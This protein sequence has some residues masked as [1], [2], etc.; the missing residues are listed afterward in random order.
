MKYFF[1]VVLL[2]GTFTLTSAKDENKS[3]YGYPDGDMQEYKE[4]SAYINNPQNRDS[5]VTITAIGQ[6]VAPSFATSPAQAYALAKRAAT[7]DAYRVIAERV[8]GVRI[9]GKD[10]IKNM[11]IKSSYV[12]TKV[13]AMIRN[14]KIIET[15]FQNGMCEVEMEITV[16]KNNFQ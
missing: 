14:A 13:D 12:N 2:L 6:G 4:E 8:K 11:A 16:D 15:T 1:I 7:A 5:L 10:T 3:P 9:N